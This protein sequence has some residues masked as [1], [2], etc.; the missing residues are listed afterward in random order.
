MRTGALLDRGGII[1][2]RIVIAA[3]TVLGFYLLLEGE[4][5]LHRVFGVA[6]VWVGV[7]RVWHHA[8]VIAR[9]SMDTD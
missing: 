1:L 5:L 8:V 7:Y 9:G 3:G 4:S 2:T 6:L